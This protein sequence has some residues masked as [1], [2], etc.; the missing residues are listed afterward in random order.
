MLRLLI[1]IAWGGEMTPCKELLE[2]IEPAYAPCSNFAGACNSLIW[3][4][5]RG[6][7]P[8][9]FLGATGSASEVELV[10]V[11]AEPGDPHY[12]EMHE[13]MDASLEYTYQCMKLGTDLLDLPLSNRTPAPR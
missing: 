5:E 8:R 1:A 7:V 12:T 4:P 13:T 10:L 3:A 6:L 11:F 2:I 9:G